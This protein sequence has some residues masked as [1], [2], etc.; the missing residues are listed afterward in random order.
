MTPAPKQFIDSYKHVLINTCITLSDRSNCEVDTAEF[1]LDLLNV[2]VDTSSA[3]LAHV[4]VEIDDGFDDIPD[5]DLEMPG[6]VRSNVL[7]YVAGYAA[8][9]YLRSHNCSTCQSLLLGS[10]D[11]H[12]NA[13]T[14]LIKYK[15]YS[16]TDSRL[17]VP[18][19]PFLSVIRSC[20]SMFLN[21][22]PNIIHSS[23]VLNKLIVMVLSTVDSA[24]WMSECSFEKVFRI[25][26]RMRIQY[27]IKYINNA[28]FELPKGRRNLKHVIFS[29][30]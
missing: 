17:H 15:A 28:V 11:E 18:A 25:Y 8:F 9:K 30:M 19:P 2:P 27:A 16:Q 4:V 29:R 21:H 14:I 5:E 26:L 10:L 7:V 13:S 20:E 3:A 24:F 1:L 22:F 23:H 12:L 6:S